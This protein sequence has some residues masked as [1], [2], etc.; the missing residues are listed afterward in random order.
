MKIYLTRGFGEKPSIRTTKLVYGGDHSATTLI[1]QYRLACR[2]QNR[3]PHRDVINQL[4]IGDYAILEK[5]RSG[6][7]L[8]PDY[9]DAEYLPGRQ[10]TKLLGDGSLMWLLGPAAC[11]VAANVTLPMREQPDGDKIQYFVGASRDSTVYVYFMNPNTDLANRLM[12][13]G[14]LFTSTAQS[15][16]TE[17]QEVRVSSHDDETFLLMQLADKP[18]FIERYLTYASAIA[19]FPEN[20]RELILAHSPDGRFENIALINGVSRCQ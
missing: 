14:Y 12:E 13:N 16:I 8:S 2:E 19:M 17:K 6:L 11:G 7:F 18:V 4:Q 10:A 20:I 3:Q 1:A 5:A 9:L 15:Y